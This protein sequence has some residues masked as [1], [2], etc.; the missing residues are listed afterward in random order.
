MYEC[1]ITLEIP[2]NLRDTFKQTLKDHFSDWHYSAIDGDQ[3]I[4]AGVKVYASRHYPANKNIDNIFMDMQTVGLKLSSLGYN[5]IRK[6]IEIIVYD[7]KNCH[8]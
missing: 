2:A 4:G 6:K 8:P 5:V 1:H 7:T 3:T